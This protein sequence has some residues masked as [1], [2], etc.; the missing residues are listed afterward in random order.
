MAK[1]VSF[2]AMPLNS[3][4]ER[5]S[6]QLTQD[7]AQMPIQ[8]FRQAYAYFGQTPELQAKILK[9]TGFTPKDFAPEMDTHL[10]SQDR[11]LQTISVRAQYEQIK[12]IRTLVGDD[13][14]L[15]AIS[16]W[17]P[18]SQGALDI[19]FRSAGTLEEGL[20]HL[21]QY[22][23]KRAPQIQFSTNKTSQGLRIKITPVFQIETADWRSISEIVFLN[24]SAMIR[25]IIPEHKI[26]SYSKTIMYHWS[27]PIP[28]YIGE[29]ESVFFGQNKFNANFCGIHFSEEIL[30]LTSPYADKALLNFS[31]KQ[32]HESE[33]LSKDYTLIAPRIR[34]LLNQRLGQKSGGTVDA[35]MA[36]NHLNITPRTLVRKLSAEGTSYRA[37]R[38]DVLKKKAHDLI[39][40]TTMTRDD[41][42]H[43][44]GYNDGASLSRSCKRWFGCSLREKRKSSR[45]VN[46]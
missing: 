26:A 38:E 35:T 11:N 21:V 18:A 17:Q 22:A 42:A 7:L 45:S 30:N 25:S 20:K 3:S 13:F 41:I 27:F 23:W 29:L 2:Y 19:A 34:S 4:P 40:N 28:E 36:A 31:L 32:L 10:A 16:I 15:R 5:N 6:A 24:L 43:T 44:L 39:F 1:Y 37:L 14:P 12:N 46:L 9:N 8:Y 33:I